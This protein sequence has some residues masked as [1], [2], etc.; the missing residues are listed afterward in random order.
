MAEQTPFTFFPDGA[1]AVCGMSP[2]PVSPGF[3]K[4]VIVTTGANVQEVEWSEGDVKGSDKQFLLP[5]SIMN[6]FG[7]QFLDFI[8]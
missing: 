7:T 1:P 8:L 6:N 5:P 2:P 3:K 4:E